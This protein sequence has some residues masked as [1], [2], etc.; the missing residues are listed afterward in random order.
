MILPVHLTV[1]NY[2]IFGKL[3]RKSNRLLAKNGF[4]CTDDSIRTIPLWTIDGALG[5]Y[6]AFQ[7]ILA[8]ALW[9]ILKT[10]PKT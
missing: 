2:K 7:R 4:W 3:F 1:I 10:I 8:T 9:K 6:F 5:R